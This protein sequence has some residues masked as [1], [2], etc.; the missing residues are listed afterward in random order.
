MDFRRNHTHL[1]GGDTHQLHAFSNLTPN[2]RRAR[3]GY[4]S[5]PRIQHITP[6]NGDIV[7]FSLFITVI[8]WFRLYG[9]IIPFNPLQPK[10]PMG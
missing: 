7:W 8:V 2:L 3:G 10:N 4:T 1:V 5:K 6:Q 9:V